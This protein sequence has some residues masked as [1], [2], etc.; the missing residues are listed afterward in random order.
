MKYHTTNKSTEYQ[1]IGRPM[2]S[3][4]PDA[5]SAVDKRTCGPIR[6]GTDANNSPSPMSPVTR[7]RPPTRATL[8]TA[9]SSPPPPIHHRRPPSITSAATATPSSVRLSSSNPAANQARPRPR[10]A[11]PARARCLH[12][13]GSAA[14]PPSSLSSTMT[15]CSSLF[16]VRW[17]S[18]ALLQMG[19]GGGYTVTEIEW[20]QVRGRGCG[21]PLPWDPNGSR[22]GMGFG[23][24]RGT[25][26]PA[27]RRE[28]GHILCTMPPADIPPSASAFGSSRV[29]RRA[30]TH[31]MATPSSLPSQVWRRCVAVRRPA[32]GRVPARAA[33]VQL[34]IQLPR[35]LVRPTWLAPCRQQQQSASPPLTRTPSHQHSVA[36]A[37]SSWPFLLFSLSAEPLSSPIQ[38]AAHSTHPSTYSTCTFVL[39]ATIRKL[40]LLVP[41]MSVC[42]L[43]DVCTF[44]CL[45]RRSFRL[46]DRACRAVHSIYP[47]TRLDVSL[48]F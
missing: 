43:V 27:A 38:L 3:L 29:C 17:A 21:C 4:T 14:P 28:Q 5:T 1:I 19:G 34:R 31:S 47:T 7:R 40:F 16:L 35:G 10:P 8:H 25:G 37:S 18:S 12:H 23:A 36:T 9:T 22:L 48:I 24:G 13:K 33:P 26:A 11:A 46:G 20:V 2:V 6:C 39:D 32:R 44:D 42:A 30:G 45:P 15:S 41:C